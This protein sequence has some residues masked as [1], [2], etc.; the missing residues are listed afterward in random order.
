MTRPAA[1][2]FLLPLLAALILAGPARAQDPL[3]AARADYDAISG[4]WVEPGR[5]CLDSSNTWTFGIEG[6]R[7]GDNRFSLMGI[8][9]GPGTIRL[10]LVDPQTGRRL[11]L[12]LM[13][14]NETLRIRGSGVAVTLVPCE[15]FTPEPVLPPAPI[16]AEPLDG[17]PPGAPARDGAG[18][19][20]GTAGADIPDITAEAAY[21]TRMTG[22]WRGPDGTCGWRLGNTRIFAD[23][24]A[25]DVVNIS[26][27]ADRIGVQALRE[28]G[29][30]ATFTLVPQGAATAT[31]TRSVVGE[32]S[33]GATLTRC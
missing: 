23:G 4:E 5:S 13:R 31:I 32:D 17:P 9:A 8:G 10:D 33:A 30:P 19:G 14:A 12:G 25:Y 6:V 21:D 20:D 7:A 22:A 26:G 1:T 2:P 16:T 15:R 18:A 27:T 11:P 24:S 29:T 28:D 3:A